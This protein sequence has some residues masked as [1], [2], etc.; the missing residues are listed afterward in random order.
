MAGPES[1]IETA[2]CK[3]AEKRGLLQ[4]KFKTP[5]RRNA[6]DRIYFQQPAICFFIEFKA[7]GE[8]AR[9]GQ[10]REA[11]KLRGYGFDV[12]FIDNIEKGKEVIDSYV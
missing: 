12:W 8:I 9:P 6:H 10:I 7:P 11:E 1:T 4:R 5:G 3:Y 2:V